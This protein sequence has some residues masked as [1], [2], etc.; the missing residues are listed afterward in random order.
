VGTRLFLG[1]GIVLIIMGVIVV[2][3]AVALNKVVNNA[4]HVKGESLPFAIEA[5]EM[6]FHVVQVQQWLTDVSATHDEG[7]FEEAETAARGVTAGIEAF[8]DMFREENDKEALRMMETL[9]KDFSEYYAMGKEMAHAYVN[10]GIEA[11]NAIMKDFDAV[12]AHLADEVRE[13]KELQID[14]ATEMTGAIVSAAGEV[15]KIMYSLSGIALAIGILIAM[16]VTRSITRPLSAGVT[17]ADSMAKGDLSMN[18]EEGGKDETGQL[19]NSMKSMVEKLRG[20]VSDVI[21]AADNVAAGSEELSSSSEEMSQGASEQASSAEEA[22]SSMEE[23][24]A[25]IRQ[26]ADNAQQTEKISRKAAEDAEQS[27]NAVGQAVGAMKQIAEKITII[28]EIARQT[29]LLALNAAIEAARAGEHGKGFAVVAAEVRKLAERSQQAAGEITEIS[30]SSVEV[31]EKAGEMLGKLVPDIQKTA[32]LVQEISA[33]SN[34]QNAGAEQINRAIQQLDQVTQQ[35][36]SGSEEM[37]STSEE[38]SSQAQHLQGVVA[39][40]KLGN[41]NGH[42]AL[43]GQGFRKPVQKQQIPHLAHQPAQGAPKAAGTHQT[44]A[45]GEK[46]SDAGVELNLKAG[47][48]ERDEEFERF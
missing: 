2:F 26:N 23:M 16:F 3:T 20:I 48:D 7:G 4:E 31:A 18:I 32:E 30:S 11:G 12:S 37:A 19:L 9:E 47:P 5:E 40:F 42:R 15:K 35:N 27:G 24:A 8:K 17:V 44:G 34:E 28:E 39:F 29:N 45:A 25:N 41:G 38:L 10:E 21:A 43:S 6:A 36:A 22:S 1:F 46:K 14:E 33:A 13:L